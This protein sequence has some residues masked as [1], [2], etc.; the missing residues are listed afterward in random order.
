MSM[1]TICAWFGISR[2]A[3]Y[4]QCQRQSRTAAQERQVLEQV[5]AV[6][7]RHPHMGVRKLLYKLGPELRQAGLFLGRDRFF[8]LLRRNDL[9][10]KPVKR[11]RRTTWAGLW[12][13]PNLLE[14]LAITRV[15]QVWVADIT[16]LE[17]EQGFCYLS[18][19][20]DAYSR[21]IVGYDLSTSLSVE[22]ALRSL[23]MAIAQ[24]ASALAGLIHHSDHGV[25]YTSH[26]YRDC[27]ADK[28]MRSSMGEVGNCYENALAERMNG[29]LKLEY[30][31]DCCFVDPDQARQAVR[32][33]VWLYNF[34]RPHLALDYQVPAQFH[35]AQ[36]LADQR[37]A[38]YV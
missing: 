13:C 22:G 14:G 24:A 19:I 10:V 12:R 31:L 27:L 30:G 32:E 33:A 23:K 5:R 29:I 15:N 8:D 17:T 36:L 7:Q 35:A 26:D 25:Q 21:R 38:N 18:L 16:Y 3:H 28:G 1:A 37:L 2:Q 6:R 11:K 20:T 4:Q 9:L 34:E